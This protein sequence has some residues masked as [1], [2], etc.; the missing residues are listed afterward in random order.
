MW[1]C[2][3]PSLKDMTSN[4]YYRGETYT[5]NSDNSARQRQMPTDSCPPPSVKNTAVI[6]YDDKI[7]V[8]DVYT[9]IYEGLQEM[10]QGKERYV[11]ASDADNISRFT[12]SDATNCHKVVERTEDDLDEVKS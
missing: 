7:L 5:I 1:F 11:T 12:V 4:Q 3:T 8:D 10:Q 6:G 9:A 2:K